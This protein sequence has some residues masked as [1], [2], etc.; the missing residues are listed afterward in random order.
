MKEA[1]FVK[2]QSTNGASFTQDSP[3]VI[4]SSTAGNP[5]HT[6]TLSGNGGITC[7]CGQ[8]ARRGVSPPCIV[9]ARMVRSD[10]MDDRKLAHWLFHTAHLQTQRP[11]IHSNTDARVLTSQEIRG[12]GA[13]VAGS[14]LSVVP[15]S[16]SKAG[17]PS[18]QARLRA[19]GNC[20][21]HDEGTK[22][23]W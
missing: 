1:A 5:A 13:G 18:H 3:L 11:R 9:A 22:K 2:F 10:A 20:G 4:P 6:L 16:A 15:P 21:G 12:A 23:A 14:S 7:T 17:C 8:M 19:G